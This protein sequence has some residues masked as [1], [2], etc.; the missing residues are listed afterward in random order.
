MMSKW[1]VYGLLWDEDGYAFY[2]NGTKIYNTDFGG[3]SQA[4]EY[5]II[6]LELAEAKYLS[7]KNYKSQMQVDY[8][9]VYQFPKYL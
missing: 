3:A 5:M 7:N 4:E 9:R 6:S 1:C 8:V 2:F